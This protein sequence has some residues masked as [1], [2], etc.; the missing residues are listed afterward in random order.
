MTEACG[1]HGAE[2]G[3]RQASGRRSRPWLRE[4][5]GPTSESDVQHGTSESEVPPQ[6]QSDEQHGTSGNEQREQQEQQHGRSGDIHAKQ[7]VKL[8][9]REG[10]KKPK[11]EMLSSG[12][13]AIFVD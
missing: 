6:A 13:F 9:K 12:G 1:R 3:W 5:E 10:R 4:R 7:H 2:A 11:K 8:E